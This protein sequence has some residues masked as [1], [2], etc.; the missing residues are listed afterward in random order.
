MMGWLDH[1]PVRFDPVNYGVIEV[2]AAEM[3]RC[4]TLVDVSPRLAIPP[5]EVAVQQT[6]VNEDK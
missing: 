6:P 4:T 3:V 2:R 5:D 1:R